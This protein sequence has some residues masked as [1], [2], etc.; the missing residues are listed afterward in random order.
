VIVLVILAAGSLVTAGIAHWWP[1]GNPP[2]ACEQRQAVKSPPGTARSAV[3]LD[4][5]ASASGQVAVAGQD[6]EDTSALAYWGVL[7]GLGLLVAALI[8]ATLHRAPDQPGTGRRSTEP[9]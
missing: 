9:D 7:A 6:C 3:A 4:D 8:L 1:S 5:A 2:A